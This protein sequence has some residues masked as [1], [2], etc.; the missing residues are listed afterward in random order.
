M[1]DLPYFQ[2]YPADCDTDEKVKSMSDAEL[3]FYV[4]CLNH[5]WLNRGLPA[6]SKERARCLRVS[7]SYLSKMWARVGN[8]FELSPHDQNRLVNNRQ[9]FERSKALDKS[10]NNTRAVRTRYERSTNVDERSENVGIRASDSDSSEVSRKEDAVKFG[11]WE[12]DESFHPLIVLYRQ[13]GKPVIDED[14]IDA[15]WAWKILDFEQKRMRIDRLKSNL[16]RHLYNDPTFIPA[17]RKFIERE[18]KRELRAPKTNGA[19]VP[20]GHHYRSDFVPIGM[21]PCPPDK[22]PPDKPTTMEDLRAAVRAG[23]VSG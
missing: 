6:D 8:C 10:K 20:A 11:S 1:P 18:W 9:E 14:F 21:G 7:E 15:W 3:G 5:A 12:T 16:D 4:R 2:W 17:P 22:M 19:P 13:S 23:K